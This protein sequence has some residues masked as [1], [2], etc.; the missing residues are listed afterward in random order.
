VSN[1][2]YWILF[3]FSQIAGVVVAALANAHTHPVPFI[4]A[5]IL[6]FPGSLVEFVP[7]ITGT[8]AMILIFPINLAAWY[9]VR[10]FLLRD[11]K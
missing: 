11:S 8:A 4:L 5:N 2:G 6:L 1:T 3:A 9:L 7:R 10:K